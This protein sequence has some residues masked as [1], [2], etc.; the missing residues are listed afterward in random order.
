M[1]TTVQHCDYVTL[2]KPITVI[3]VITIIISIF[4]RHTNTIPIQINTVR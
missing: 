3:E 4:I 2:F 1:T